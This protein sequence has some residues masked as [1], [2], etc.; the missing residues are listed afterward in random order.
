MQKEGILTL[1]LAMVFGLSFSSENIDSSRLKLAAA[2]AQAAY[3]YHIDFDERT[4]TTEVKAANFLKDQGFTIELFSDN[5]Q[6][7]QNISNT[8]LK[9]DLSYDLARHKQNYAL[10]EK[11]W[12]LNENYPVQTY[13]SNIMGS[14]VLVAKN[15]DENTVI[16]S[17]RG[18]DNITNWVLDTFVVP[19]FFNGTNTRAH[20]GFQ[21]YLIEIMLN[22]RFL[23]WMD[24]NVDN[25]TKVIISGHSLGGA[26]AT[27]FSA[28]M[29]EDDKLKSDHLSVIT[30]A[31]PAVGQY[32]FVAYFKDKLVDYIWVANVVDPVI[33]MTQAF[34]YHHFGIS[35]FFMSVKES[36]VTHSMANYYDHISHI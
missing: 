16:I 4:K 6:I 34:G 11:N 31:A 28:K 9:L 18:S 27:L 30:F 10:F 14:Q 36:W 5:A 3:L 7:E 29:T 24:S 12:H 17:F 15:S 8:D 2:G 21:L 35:Y 1:G 23:D 25:N 20:T 22:K 19:S 26:V 32:D 13:S 33:Y